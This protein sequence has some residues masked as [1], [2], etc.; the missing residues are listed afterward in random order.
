MKRYSIFWAFGRRKGGGG[1]SVVA[2]KK[3]VK[4]SQ[5]KFTKY[6][7]RNI[8]YS[9]QNGFR[10]VIALMFCFALLCFDCSSS[11]RMFA[12]FFSSF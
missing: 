4:T 5:K 6:D 9:W 10:Q 1:M 3:E 11:S 12:F 8:N 7:S 2:T